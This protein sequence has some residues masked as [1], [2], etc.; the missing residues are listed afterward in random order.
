M[1]LLVLEEKL[2][3]TLDETLRSTL[4]KW[5][6]THRDDLDSREEVQLTL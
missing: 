5:W 4:S 1:S 3:S 2:V 6:D